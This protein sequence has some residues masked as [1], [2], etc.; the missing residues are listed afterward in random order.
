MKITLKRKPVTKKDIGKYLIDPNGYSFLIVDVDNNNH[1]LVGCDWW[2]C[3][4][5]RFFW[6]TKENELTNVLIDILTPCREINHD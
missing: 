1:F 6:D 3:D 5:D 2:S 4:T